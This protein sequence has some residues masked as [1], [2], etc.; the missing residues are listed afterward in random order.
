MSPQPAGLSGAEPEP[1]RP[2]L[3]SEIPLPG[4]E[5]TTLDH[6]RTDDWHPEDPTKN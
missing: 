2:N 6:V 4:A 3:C 5:T 1:F